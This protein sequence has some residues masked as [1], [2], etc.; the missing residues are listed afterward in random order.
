MAADAT[1]LMACQ[2]M[3]EYGIKTA[4]L[5]PG[6]SKLLSSLSSRTHAMRFATSGL[7]ALRLSALDQAIRYTKVLDVSAV[8][9]ANEKESKKAASKSKGRSR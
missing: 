2:I 3:L 6:G 4:W 5:K 1:E 7:L 8:S 9:R